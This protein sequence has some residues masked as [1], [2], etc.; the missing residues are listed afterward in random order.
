MTFEDGPNLNDKS[1]TP[2]VYTSTVSSLVNSTHDS[3]HFIGPLDSDFRNGKGK[4]K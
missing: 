4:S 1:L 3:A 2:E